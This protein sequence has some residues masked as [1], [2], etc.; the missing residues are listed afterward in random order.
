MEARARRLGPG[1]MLVLR[2][3]FPRS[4]EE[5]LA[6]RAGGLLSAEAV[7]KCYRPLAPRPTPATLAHWNRL[8]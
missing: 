8:G 7:A 6:E 1:E 5:A 2:R 4:V 3:Q